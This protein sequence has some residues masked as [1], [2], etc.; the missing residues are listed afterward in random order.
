MSSSPL[1]EDND[2][3][4]I[5]ILNALN[6]DGTG[7]LTSNVTVVKSSASE[8]VPTISVTEDA[9]ANR[10]A[11]ALLQS[12]AMRELTEYLEGSSKDTTELQTFI[13]V[14]NNNK[15]NEDPNNKEPKGDSNDS[16]NNKRNEDPNNKE[17]KD[18]DNNKDINNNNLVFIFDSNEDASAKRSRAKSSD[19][20]EDPLPKKPRSAKYI[21]H[22]KR[23]YASSEDDEEAS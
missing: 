4:I 16:N 7:P 23:M 15:R 3:E 17:P 14:Y 5:D 10:D 6:K 21:L 20:D 1:F 9:Q 2:Q 18:D 19:D 13:D 12:E 11:A 22:W 8:D